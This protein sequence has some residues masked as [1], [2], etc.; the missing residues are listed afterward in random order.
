MSLELLQVIRPTGDYE[1]KMEP[2]IPKD[3]LKRLYRLTALTRNL[4]IRELQLHTG[5]THMCFE[6][7]P[8]G[9]QLLECEV[10]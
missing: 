8:E 3:E 4:D 7:N 6:G 9:S 10:D 2:E 1:E 5:A